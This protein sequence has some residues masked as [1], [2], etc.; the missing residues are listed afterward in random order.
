MAG[1]ERVDKSGVT[2][3]RLKET[4]AINKSLS[5]LGNVIAALQNKQQHVPYRDS[6]LT[7]L[8]QDSLGGNSKSLMFV[9]VNPSSSSVNETK[10]SLEFAARVASVELGQA[11]RNTIKNSPKPEVKNSK[12]NNFIH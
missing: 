12:K 6:K 1:S 4:Q 9:Q 8:L 7:Y 3:D 5:A 11:T 2:D 10:N